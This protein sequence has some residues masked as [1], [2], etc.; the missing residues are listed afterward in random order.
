MAQA[1]ER[2][3]RRKRRMM[4]EVNGERE[5]NRKHNSYLYR[6]TVI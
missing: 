2:N 1:K 3:V 5:E 6:Y 4:E